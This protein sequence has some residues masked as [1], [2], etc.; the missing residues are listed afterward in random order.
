MPSPN[1]IE[2]KRSGHHCLCLRIQN[3]EGFCFVLGFFSQQGN[4][5][6]NVACLLPTELKCWFM[7]FLL[8]AG[9]WNPGCVKKKSSNRFCEYVIRRS[10][11]GV[12]S[13]INRQSEMISIHCWLFFRKEWTDLS[14]HSMHA[15]MSLSSLYCKTQLTWLCLLRDRNPTRGR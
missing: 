10:F 14:Q 5:L 4:S 3:N 1:Y 13:E 7:S 6:E 12:F 11:S 8:D 9:N 15:E 2:L